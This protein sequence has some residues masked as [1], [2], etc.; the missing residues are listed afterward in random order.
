MKARLATG[1]PHKLVELQRVLPDWQLVLVDNRAFP[2]E[3]G[4]TYA[5]NARIK[6]LF[7]RAELRPGEWAIGDDSGIEAS[8]LGGRPGVASARWAEDGV[9][10]LLEE[11]DGIADR[12]ARY[13]CAIVAISP[14]GAEVAVEGT[15]E[16]LVSGPPRGEGGFGYDPIF[17][18]RG[19][20][21]TVAELGDDW[22]TIHSHRALAAVALA[23][24]LSAADPARRP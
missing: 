10:R 1:N 2:D 17:V 5:E 14:E 15:L 8:G 18:P 4:L 7:A 16:G 12:A 20:S 19:E 24:A 13:V 11:L 9:A 6:A 21:L 23:T 22:K 3:T